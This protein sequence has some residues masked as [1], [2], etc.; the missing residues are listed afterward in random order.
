M[1][2]Q[3]KKRRMNNNKDGDDLPI[4]ELA[5]VLLDSPRWKREGRR[6]QW[7]MKSV[8]DHE[9]VFLEPLEFDDVYDSFDVGCEFL[10]KGAVGK[11]ERLFRDV[12]RKAPLHIDA[13][14]HLAII[15]DEKG[16]E[17]EAL[18]LWEQ[19]V[20][21]GRQAFPKTFA[22]GDRLEWGWLEN[23]PF[24]RCL[25]GLALAVHDAGDAGR[26]TCLLEE[27]LSYNP[28]DNQGIREFLIGAYLEEQKYQNAL[29]L[30]RKY[31]DDCS[32]GILYG[33][34]LVLF[35]LG[36]QE[37]AKRKLLEA[38]NYSPKIA[39]ELL[40][41]NHKPPKSDMPGYITVGGWD[42]AYEYWRCFG[43]FWDEEALQWLRDTTKG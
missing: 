40:K 33:Y 12:L 34:P 8:G 10:E 26:S 37:P 16:Q 30:C 15:L 19:G 2:K 27:L 35:K 11:A 18:Q 21:I 28:D 20:A 6:G 32:P 13:L 14:H 25:H 24:L 5:N 31:S 4:V 43:R 36:K 39:K 1:K 42:E 29:Q 23:R 38:V 3:S 17:T 41:K 7:V 22:P 9:W